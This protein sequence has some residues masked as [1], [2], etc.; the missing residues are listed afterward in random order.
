MKDRKIELPPLP[1]SF[2]HWKD[3][4]PTSS[5]LVREDDC[6]VFTADQMQEYVIAD[7]Q[8][9]GE[10]VAAEYVTTHAASIRGAF[11]TLKN[12]VSLDEEDDPTYYDHELRALDTALSTIEAP[13]PAEPVKV[14]SDAIEELARRMCL[15]YS[16][17]SDPSMRQ[18]T[19]GMLTLHCFARA[20]LARYG[21]PVAQTEPC[22]NTYVQ[23]VP[24]QCDRIVWR[25][26][27]YHLHDGTDP[28]AQEPMAYAVI[29]A[30]TGKIS[31][32]VLADDYDHAGLSE[33]RPEHAIPLISAAPVAARPDASEDAYIIDR[34]SKLL[35]EIAV[36]VRGPEQPRHRHGY[37]D[38]P[39]RVAALKAASVAAHPDHSEQDLNMVA[40]TTGYEEFGKEAK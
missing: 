13:Q 29:A 16:H 22:T 1:S 14:P 30:N 21:Q 27:Y 24:D 15:K 3:P 11:E 17:S 31:R 40:Q 35:A 32:L 10:P 4:T 25:G 28:V 33:M 26:R 6:Y 34:M 9:R 5:G 7:R 12:Y 36:I 23:T 37:S 38:L 19:F 8:R 2:A 39:E 20:L 18:Y